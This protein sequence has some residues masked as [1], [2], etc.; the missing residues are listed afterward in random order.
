MG[1][2]TNKRRIGELLVDAGLITAEQIKEVLSLQSE[3]GGKIVELLISQGYL[4]PSQFLQ[5]LARQPGIASIDLSNYE[6][7]DQLI[8]LLPQSCAVK[9][10]AFPIDRMGDLLTVGM[11][12]PLDTAAIHEL[13]EVTGLRIKPLLCAPE[14]I[15][16]ALR[17]YYGVGPDGAP[18]PGSQED[19]LGLEGPLRLSSVASL[20]RRITSLPALPETVGRVREAMQDPDSSVGDVANILVLDPPI[21]ARVLGVANSAAYGFPQRVDDL[22]LAVSLLGLRETYSIV[23]SCAV[24]DLFQRSSTFDYRVFWIESMCCAAA[25]RVVAKACGRRKLFGVFSGGL[26]HDLGRVVLA[27]IV[28]ET[29][30]DVDAYLPGDK[31][32]TLEQDLLGLT[33]PE[34]GYQLAQ[35]WELPPEITEPIRFHHA[36]ALASEAKENVAIV[37]LAAVMTR[38]TGAGLDDNKH[39][40]ADHGDALGIL[41]LDEEVAEAMLDEFLQRREE[42]FRDVFG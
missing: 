6:I 16:S 35:Q 27:E 19:I 17:R 28:P 22:T 9:H 36:P 30:A 4:S 29:Y 5:F 20:I 25:S 11:V 42:S 7:S 3:E 37:S 33:H 24:V 2:S 15:R 26:L 23:M 39:I 12:C 18:A 34:A 10:E 32:L 1:M 31:L 13:E 8:S 21:A 38:A 14:A 41:G 40:F